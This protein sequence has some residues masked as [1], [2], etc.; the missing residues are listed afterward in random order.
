MWRH[1]CCVQPGRLRGSGAAPACPAA[2][3]AA[4]SPVPPGPTARAG[5]PPHHPPPALSQVL[6]QVHLHTTALTSHKWG[7]MK[8]TDLKQK[9]TLIKTSDPLLI[10]TV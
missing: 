3:T 6:D 5:R 8:I 10:L 9:V 2:A 4:W 7:E 1:F